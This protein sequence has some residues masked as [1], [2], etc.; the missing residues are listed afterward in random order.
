MKSSPG[1]PM[2]SIARGVGSAARATSPAATPSAPD[3]PEQERLLR[4]HR[5]EDPT[6]ARA[7]ASG[8]SRDIGGRRRQ[9]RRVVPVFIRAS[10][11]SSTSRSIAARP[12]LAPSRTR[13]STSSPAPHNARTD[14]RVCGI[15]EHPDQLGWRSL[16]KENSPP[17]PPT[18]TLADTMATVRSSRR[19]GCT[20]GTSSRAPRRRAPRAFRP[21]RRGALRGGA[22]RE[23]RVA[24]PPPRP[25]RKRPTPARRPAGA[26]R[27]S[28]SVAR[29]SAGAARGPS[30]LPA[31]AS[32]TSSS[33]P[34]TRNPQPMRHPVQRMQVEGRCHARPAR[35][36]P[37]ERP[38]PHGT[39]GRRARTRRCGDIR[40]G[41]RRRARAR[42][43]AD[44]GRPRGGADAG[45]RP[46]SVAPPPRRRAR[47]RRT[48]ASFQGD[49]H[50]RSWGETTRPCVLRLGRRG[51]VRRGLD[52]V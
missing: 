4:Q 14:T 13:R 38:P 20:S 7:V 44:A 18:R 17:P 34:R 35:Q 42:R 25:R 37:M 52:S 39:R 22:S 2:S 27:G 9:E 36:T 8:W 15:F 3:R 30:R 33:P 31:A 51:R 10:G 49:R 28:A 32:R 21:L 48:L 26:A 43:H 23:A 19:R 24:V 41:S 1:K 40:R 47:D 5:G 45:A 46:E 16:G 29:G 6:P 50:R 11:P 12:P